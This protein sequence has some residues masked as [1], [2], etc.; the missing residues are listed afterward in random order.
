M[1]QTE[2]IRSLDQPLDT[3]ADPTRR[4]LLGLGLGA[5]LGFFAL[6][7][8]LWRLQVYNGADYRQQ[9]DN[10]RFRLRRVNALRGL[11]LDRDG[12][13]L[14]RNRPSYAVAIVPADLP[15]SPEAVFRRLGRL[16]LASPAEIAQTVK[17]RA[18]PGD[19]F[20][21]VTIRAG[22]DARLAHTIEERNLELPGVQ[23]LVQPV[24]EYVDGRL[25][26][27][28]IGM[29]SRIDAEEYEQLRADPDL[30]YAQDDLVG[31]M[32]VELMRESELRGR[33]GQKR[34]EV[35]SAGHELRVLGI[36]RARS[37]QNLVLTLDLP[38][39]R[40]ITRLLA[41]EL[42]RFEAAS[43]V[44]LDPRD[45]QVLAMVHLPTYDNNAFSRELSDEEFKG[46]LDDPR[47]PLVNSAIAGVFSPGSIFKIVTAVA[48][49]QL[50]VVKPDTRFECTGALTFPSRES[51]GGIGR[52]PCWAVHGPQDVATALANSCNVFFYQIGGG[53]PRGEPQG[54]GIDRLGE[55][56]KAFGLGEPTGV[57]LPNEVD[58]FFP[59]PA[60]K[61]LTYREP[62]VRGDTYNVSI[63]QGYLAATPIQFA[64][65][66]AAIANGGRLYRPQVV[67]RTT[68]ER[69]A[70][71]R[72]F[73]PEL[74][75][76]LRL[77]PSKL[78]VV[79][80]G[81]RYGLQI[82]RTENGTTFTGTS[83]EWDLRDLPI[84]GKTGTA[85][86]GRPDASGHL[87]THGWFAGYAPYDAPQ[88]ALSLFLKR[89]RGPNDAA[90]L[91]RRIFA[92]YFGVAE[93]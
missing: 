3:P 31:K 23:V 91:A 15:R 68:D 48:A 88:I 63:G 89:G 18:I 52:I 71:L 10:N 46:L 47:R 69:G 56:A 32:G 86:W 30:E 38:L 17:Q 65:V 66:A 42:P 26:S 28:V 41:E 35:D 1:R 90:R 67:L 44:A 93:V 83:W 75:R 62:W 33:P 74:I 45:G 80:R 40:E 58:G 6:G 12:Q 29:V 27:H 24:R 9:A 59:S 78:A 60:W 84:A 2:P 72:D 34:S 51:P 61:R 53:D 43:A 55:W 16:I 70:T 7:A 50:D 22:V 21:P 82:G 79:Q 54:V 39:Q 5:G 19:P 81:L 8:Q 87:P 4:R 92:Y 64:S 77:D 11:I 37:G 76:D 57:D 14:A 36:D 20:A 13:P 73:R 49:L 85:E 25:A